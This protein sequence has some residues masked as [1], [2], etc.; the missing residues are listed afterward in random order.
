MK[1]EIKFGQYI[2][3]RGALRAQILSGRGVSA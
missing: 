3:Y 1:R 2:V